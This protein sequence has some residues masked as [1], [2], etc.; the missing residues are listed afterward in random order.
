MPK[1]Y[2]VIIIGA[3]I[4]GSM[5]ARFLSKYQQDILLLEKEVDVGMG[6]SAA[7]SA[8]LHA[9]YDALPGSN[10]AL[11]NLM[12]V[13]MW[14]DLS[15]ELGIAYSRCGDYVVAVN[16]DEVRVLEDLLERGQ[17]NGVPD[18][19]IISGDEM[20]QREPLIRPDV[21]AALWAPTGAIGDPFA[22]TVAA[23]EN[24][25]MNGVELLRETACEDFIME[26][27]RIIG[28][29]TSQGEFFCRWAINAAGLY[30]DEVMH[31]AGVRPEF[32]IQPRRGE[33]VILDKAD[34]QLSETTVIFPTPT[35]KGKGILLAGTLHGNVIVGP[36]ANFVDSKDNKEMTKEGIQEIW[37]GGNK[38]VPAIVRKHIIAQFAGLRATGNAP[39]PNPE[40]DYNQDFIIEIPSTVTGLVNL[41]GIESPGFTAAPAIAL[42]VIELLQG[43][44]EALVEKPDWNPN[45]V[46]RPVFRHLDREQQ[47]ALIAKDPAYAR[48]VCRCE[49]VTEGE[50]LAEIH[51]PIPADTYDALKRRTWLGTGRCQGG[52]D[53]PRVV[54][55]LAA[56]LGLASEE[57]TKKGG[58]SEF[59]YRPTKDVEQ[60]HL[61]VEA[62]I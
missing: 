30:A 25:V 58:R 41:G 23:A 50:I 48:I 8:I 37:E 42:K 4:V 57:I 26:G 40:I 49:M 13:E 12:A 10:K 21:V 22:A 34:F 61:T 19:E 53:M 62:L 7:N 33:Y 52:F 45:R 44:G 9:G 54:A 27:N 3:G 16:D 36:N 60:D 1:K 31:K 11:T 35:D 38:L 2:D 51:A 46:P 29:C 18:I 39:S 17:R 59:L 43:A 20:R 47:A 5:V 6:A 55:I 24:A 14:P 56:E 28:V 32:Y 15:Q